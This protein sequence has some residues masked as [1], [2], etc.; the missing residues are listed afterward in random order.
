[1]TKTTSIGLQLDSVECT[2]RKIS[3]NL[4]NFG[5]DKVTAFTMPIE[6]VP[7]TEQQIDAFLGKYTHRSLYNQ[8]ADK[9]WAPMPWVKRCNGGVLA[10]DD[11][12]D[13]E[14]VEIIV[15]GNRE[16]TFE[17]EDTDDDDTRPA[18]RLTHIRLEPQVGGLTLLSFH[19]SVR[20]DLK[21]Q[22]PL[23]LEHQCRPITITLGDMSV[24]AKKGAQ[25]DLFKQ[26]DDGDG[27][28]KRD[29]ALNNAGN[30][31]RKPID[32]T[33]AASRARGKATQPRAG[34]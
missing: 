30:G 1:M 17:A 19:L 7:L 2:M 24:I 32:G 25:P 16:L 31:E 21:K 4:L 8:G 29:A 13:V 23:L 11:E 18:A 22:V 5:E 33:T 14:D 27:Q 10:I 9:L 20:P 12:F 6:G 26:A 28:E 34:H 3:N 15:S